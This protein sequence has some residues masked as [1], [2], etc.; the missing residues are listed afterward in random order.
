[1]S[2]LGHLPSGWYA[3]LHGGARG[4]VRE[5]VYLFFV[6]EAGPLASVSGEG[7][8]PLPSESRD[9]EWHGPF[10]T[11]RAARSADLTCDVVRPCPLDDE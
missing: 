6:P 8:G 1:M 2:D 7:F 10:A 3:A 9:W 5:I 4:L 11:P